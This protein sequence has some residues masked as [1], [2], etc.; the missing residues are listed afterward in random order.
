MENK[1]TERDKIVKELEKLRWT[2]IKTIFNGEVKVVDTI[3]KFADFILAREQALKAEH[4]KVLES[5]RDVI[6]SIVCDSHIDMDER[7]IAL[8][9]IT[10]S[11]GKM[12]GE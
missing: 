2:N 11:L 5:L 3:D 8:S 6:S 1:L 9:I 10:E 4:R 7:N 12:E